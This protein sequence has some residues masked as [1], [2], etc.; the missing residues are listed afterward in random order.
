MRT[1]ATAWVRR[2][3]GGGSYVRAVRILHTSDWHLGGPSTARA[4]SGTRRRTSTTC[5]TSSSAEQVDLVVVAGDI[6]DRALPPV[7]AVRLADEAFAR[8]AASRARVVVTSGNHDSA[9]RLGFGSRLIDAAGVHIRTDAA[10][11]GRP[12]L[13]DDEHGPVAVYGLPYLDPDALREP[14]GLPGR[15][16]EAALTEAMRRV[17]ADLA[18][19]PR[20][21]LG[22]AGPRLRRRRRAQR[23]R[24]RHQRRRRL[25]RADVGLRRRRLRRARPPARPAHADRRGPLQRL[26]AGLLLLRGRPPQGLLAGR[27][28]RRR[29]RRRPSSSTRRSRGRW[30]GSAATSTTCW[31]TRRCAGHEQPGCRRRSP[32]TP[33]R[34][35]RWSGCAGASRT[36]W[37]SR[38]E[39]ARP[40]DS[41]APRR[42]H[43]RPHRPRH[44]PR[45]RRRA[46]RHARHRRRV[47]AA[48]R[49]R[50]TPAATTPT[51]TS[52]A[53][54][55]WR[56]MRLHH[57]EV[58]AFGPFAEHGRGRLRRALR[59]R[60]VPAHRRHRR[61]QDQRPRRRLLRAVRRGPRRPQSAKR[62]RCDQA[63]DGE[64]PAGHA[65]GHPRR[66][67]VPD[68]P[69]PRVG[70]AQEAR[71]RHH[72]RAGLASGSASGVDGD[73]APAL[74]PAR[75]GRPPGHRPGRHEPHPVLPGGDAAPGPVPG[76]PAGQL[77][78][79]APAAPAAVP[80]RALRGRRALAA[81]PPP[82]AAP[83]V[84]APTTTGSPTWSAGSARPP[85]SPLPD[86]LGPARPR[87][88]R[89]RRVS[90][91]QWSAPAD[92]AAE[93]SARAAASSAG[94]RSPTRRRRARPATPAGSSREPSSA[95]PTRSP[96]ATRLDADGARPRPAGRRL[97]RA[98][99]AAAVAPLRRLADQ[100]RAGRR[101][102]PG[103]QRRRTRPRP[104]AGVADGRPRR[105]RPASTC[106]DRGGRRGRA[107]PGPSLPR[108]DALG[109]LRREVDA[110]H[111]ARAAARGRA[112]RARRPALPTCPP[113]SRRC[114]SASPRPAS[115][116]ATCPESRDAVGSTAQQTGRPPALAVRLASEL[117]EAT[118]PAP[119]ARSTR[120]SSS[121]RTG[122]SSRSSASTGWPPSSPAR[123]RSATSCPV[124]GSADHPQHA[125]ARRRRAR[126]RRREGRPQQVD[127]AEA[128]RHAHDAR[129]RELDRP[130]RGRP[131]HAPTATSR[132]LREAARRPRRPSCSDSPRWPRPLAD[133]RPP[134][135]AAEARQTELTARR[136][137]VGRDL[138]G[139]GRAWSAS[140]SE[141]RDHRARAVRPARRHRLR[142]PDRPRCRARRRC[143]APARR[144][145][146]TRDDARRTDQAAAAAATQLDEAA[147]GRRVRGCRRRP[148]AALD[149]PSLA[150][151]GAGRSRRTTQAVAG[152]EST[153]V[154]P[155]A[156][157]PGA[158]APARRPGPRGGPP[159]ARSTDA[160]GGHHRSQRRPREGRAAGRAGRP[161]SRPRSTPGP[162]C[163][164][165]STWSTRLAALVEGTS[166]DNRLR[167]G[168]PA[169][170]WPAGSPRWWPPPTSGCRG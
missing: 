75:R 95:M 24:A 74:H 59:R 109:V 146:L 119:A 130:A 36:P 114:A 159:A 138:R 92:S 170:S 140:A 31:P 80:H 162:R 151:A 167:C 94:P 155:G 169:T 68:R 20:H 142:H 115:R 8:L 91:T 156:A 38:F 110:R 79:A 42:A 28:R 164:T 45:L 1:G 60:P 49:R 160:R 141:C 154:R 86:E 102:R 21:P 147:A 51:S 54:R 11:A 7:D 69:L 121:R 163:A 48:A 90:S 143:H 99:R 125:S 9:Q 83:R 41:G 87:P 32:T 15:S 73:L 137:Q 112:R 168:S 84:R 57:L 76:V 93:E 78:G 14:W 71:H 120:R 124:C 65:R 64:A 161:S 133:R 165:S 61:R 56:L 10:T 111:G 139:H 153:P 19:R 63:A 30:P 104:P 27:P 103:A 149:P 55:G 97:A 77:R 62:L 150:R 131:G 29:A 81:R 39:P 89:R 5:S 47:R 18:G 100:Q 127:D 58:T 50:A 118:R 88:R 35:R 134:A 3:V 17:R 145:S 12:V 70:A 26:P 2:L 128:A 53:R 122:S 107:T 166:A 25:D 157:R 37:S 72:H 105:R 6:Y 13:L 82:R 22:R 136:E 148:D 106:R 43:A 132:A 98:R 52:C 158:P 44:R 144:R 108:E 113:S 46:A 129:V 66:P 116:S 4:C 34:S 152:A 16:H 40:R 135:I 23:L 96:S 117:A 67:P 126:R 101:A 33:G 85:A 123:S